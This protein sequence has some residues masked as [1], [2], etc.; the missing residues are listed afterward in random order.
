MRPARDCSQSNAVT[1]NSYSLGSKP[2]LCEIFY[3][4]CW[5]FSRKDFLRVNKYLSFCYFFPFAKP[6]SAVSFLLR[7]FS[8]WWENKYLI[9]TFFSCEP[10]LSFSFFPRCCT[11]KKFC[12]DDVFELL[13]RNP[14]RKRWSA[15]RWCEK[16]IISA[17]LPRFLGNKVYWSEK[18]CNWR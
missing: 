8:F 13:R 4:L 17:F 11:K 6:F 18:P 3:C 2:C 16:L 1:R 10:L 9:K 7:S 5:W 12:P 14:L 15:E